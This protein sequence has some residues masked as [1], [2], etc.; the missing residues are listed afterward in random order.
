MRTHKLL[1]AVVAMLFGLVLVT[2]VSY[3]GVEGETTDDTAD[4]LGEEAPEPALTSETPTEAETVEGEVGE[5]VEAEEAEISHIGHCIEEAHAAGTDPEDCV[6]APNPD[7]PGHQ[8]D[9]LGRRA[10]LDPARP[11]VVKFA[12]P[13]SSRAWPTAASASAATSSGPSRPRSRPSRCSWSTSPGCR[14]QVRGQPHHRG[15]RA[16]RPTRSRPIWPK[17]AEVEIAEMKARAAGR[18]RGLQGAR[19]WPICAARWPL[20]PSA[21]PSR[22]CS[23]ASTRTPRS[24]SSRT[25]STRWQRQPGQL[26]MDEVNAGPSR[27]T[28]TALLGVAKAEGQLGEVERRAVPVRPRPRGLRRAARRPRR[29]APPGQPTPADRRGPPRRRA[30]RRHHGPRLDGRRRR[31]RP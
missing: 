3:A 4:G 8:R 2:G 7:P 31:S 12:S 5:A 29:S 13:P 27:P 14:R 19:P 6:E 20:W 1:A 24:P 15:G 11:H 10:F 26:I 30:T 16:S 22:S 28:P 23:A 17:R 21:R 9:H 18:R 25:S